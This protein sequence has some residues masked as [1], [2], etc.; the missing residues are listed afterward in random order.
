VLGSDWS[1]RAFDAKGQLIWRRAA[2][3]VVWAVNVSG[4]G[5]LTIAAYG[6]GTIRWH[7]LDDGRELLT[8]Y[9]LADKQ[10]WVAWTPE[11]FYGATAGAFG[12]LQWQ[13]NRGFD[14]AAD[15]VPVNQ[16]PSLR[17]PDALALVLQELET[18]R[19]LGIADLK[20]ARRDVQIV[21]KS[22][23]APGARLH[24][25]TIGISEYG[26]K[27]RNLRLSFAARDA[28]DVA[29]ALL[30][31]QGGGLYA[32]VKPMFLHDG[33]AD[34]GGIFEALAAMD[35]NM[36]SSAGQ[37]LA[38]VMFSGHGTMIDNQFYLVPYGADSS[39]MARLK[40]SAIPATEFRSE[41]EK[42]AQR[43]RVLVLLDACR[44]AGLIGGPFGRRGAKSC[45]ER[46]QCD[47]ADV[48]YRRQGLARG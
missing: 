24:V 9:V 2:P 17:R 3:S 35:R 39:S 34:K 38:V 14:A 47:G 1:L 29:S 44:S 41:I 16:I 31:T 7:R 23:K 20:A 11:G 26:D 43:G 42:L 12:V 27:A 13:V 45:H 4:D 36:T 46:Q 25:L 19:A 10:N 6:D 30:N 33:A 28:Q 22:A 5:R 15:T 32:E 37:D 48:I 40:S 18:A 21:T 8:L